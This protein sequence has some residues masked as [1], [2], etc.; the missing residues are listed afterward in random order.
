[1]V[2]SS[3]TFLTIFM[4][5]VTALYYLPRIFIRQKNKF[6]NT[7]KNIILCIASLLF[8]AWGEPKNIVLMLLSILFN[9]VIALHID[10]EGSE[11]KR[12]FLMILSLV[13]NV[14]EIRLRIR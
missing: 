7:Y 5:F 4:P 13:F 6:Y 11:K 2:F 9:Y 8:Y 1:M 10:K 12:K 3:V 14:V